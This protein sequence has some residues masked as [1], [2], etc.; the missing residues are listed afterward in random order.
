MK[1]SYG[2]GLATRAGPE[3]CEVVREGH[4][5]ALTG[6]RTG[7]P[8]SR[9]MPSVPG[10]DGFDRPGRQHRAHRKRGEG[11]ASVM[12]VVAACGEKTKAAPSAGDSRGDEAHGPGAVAEPVHVRKHLTR[13]QGDLVAAPADGAEGRGG[14]S[15]DAIHR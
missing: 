14:K 15:K 9:E 4:G 8:S 6:V 11:R 7:R 12:V 5:E 3:S 1:E 13:E 2:E 10:A